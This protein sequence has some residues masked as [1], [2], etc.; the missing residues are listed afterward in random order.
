MPGLSYNAAAQASYFIPIGLV[1]TAVIGLISIIAE[2]KPMM[3]IY[4]VFAILSGIY[5]MLGAAGAMYVMSILGRC[6][7][8]GICARR[9]A[10]VVAFL[11]LV[12]L[13]GWYY[14][15]SF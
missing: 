14:Y 5:C 7:S 8:L 11:V 9:M 12:L 15:F 10:A 1:V 6:L 3:I 4:I 13:T 2:S